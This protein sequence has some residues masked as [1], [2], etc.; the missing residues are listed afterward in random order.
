MPANQRWQ[1]RHTRCTKPRDSRPKARWAADRGTISAMMYQNYAA[2]YDGS[3][4]I[5]FILLFI[6]YLNELL[7]RHQV[8]QRHLLDLACGTGTLA[9]IM[10]DSGWEVLG[11]D[12]SAAMLAQAEAKAANAS[13]AGTLAF[14]QSDLR[15]V[16]Q[17]VPPAAFDLVTCTY[18]SLNYLLLEDELAACLRGVAYALCPGGL[19]VGDMNTPY[20]LQHDWGSCDVHEHPGY[21]Q[22]NQS[23]FDPVAG[24]TTMV[25]TGFVG[26]D[27]HGYTRF[28]EVHIERGYP[29]ATVAALIAQA[30]LQLEAAYDCF[31]FEPPSA[32]TQRIVWVARKP[33]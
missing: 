18:D 6:S 19:F 14:V 5:R 27:D 32:R 2:V 29:A 3:G 31:T 24:T 1:A 15:T 23:H 30:G 20:F 8:Q 17:A 10:A 4:Q 26:N 11:L 33:A 28:D 25:V 12:Q 13:V 9:L 7:Q 16:D 22:V 21:I